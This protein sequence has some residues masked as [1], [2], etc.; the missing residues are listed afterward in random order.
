MARLSFV[1]GDSRDIT[2]TIKDSLGVAVDITGWTVFFTVK[3][4]K[5]DTDDN[6][7]IAK[8]VTTHTDP[9]GGITKISLSSD[10]TED[11]LGEYYFDI[12]IKTDNDDI[13]TLDNDICSF[14]HDITRRTA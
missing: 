3:E 4:N 13:F 8:D 14:E 11:L 1:R 7:K 6:A 10:D 2:L 5:E 9:T 12:Q